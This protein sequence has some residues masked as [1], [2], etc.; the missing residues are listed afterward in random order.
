MNPLQYPNSGALLLAGVVQTALAASE[1]HLY[2]AGTIVLGPTTTLADLTAEEADFT[3]YAAVTVANWLDP[4]LSE[5]GGAAI[6]SGLNDFA[7]TAPYTVPNVIQ[8][9][10]VQD[11]GGD[12]CVAGDFPVNKGIAGA[13]D[14]VRFNIELVLFSS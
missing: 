2:Q 8:G 10:W 13:G 7:I 1:V 5:L 4:L 9:W 6:D 14:G 3:G 12:L 11:A